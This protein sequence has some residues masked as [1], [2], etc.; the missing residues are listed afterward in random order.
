MLAPVGANLSAT[1]LYSLSVHIQEAWLENNRASMIGERDKAADFL[2]DALNMTENLVDSYPR[3]STE[4]Q[5]LPS[6]H[7]ETIYNEMSIAHMLLKQY[8]R[9]V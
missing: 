5:N 8:K 1:D 4:V 3:L 6:S 7:Q 2:H 9:R